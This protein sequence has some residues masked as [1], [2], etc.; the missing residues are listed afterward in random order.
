MKGKD[1]TL[2]Y[3]SKNYKEQR[4][5]GSKAKMDVER[6]MEMDG[7]RNVGLKQTHYHNP[8]AGYFMTLFSV[9]KSPWCMRAGNV[10][11]LQYPFKKYYSLLC[12]FA[13][14]RGCKVIT[15]IHDLGSFR[16]KK[17]SVVKEMKRLHRSD[18]IIAH[19]E[20]MTTWLKEHAYKNPIG[21]FEIWDYLSDSRPLP[22]KRDTACYEIIYAGEL[23][24]RKNRFLYRVGQSVRNYH[25]TLYG[26]RFASEAVE[27]PDCLTYRGYIPSD[28]LIAEVE[29]DFGLV[30]DGDSVG[31]CSG[32]WGEYLR[33]N[34]PH[35]TSLYIR[36]H[37]PLIVWEKSAMAVFVK[38]HRVGIC[39]NSLDE[40]D[41]IL[42]NMSESTYQDM[43]Q[44]V[45]E[46]SDKLASGYAFRKAIAS[47]LS[48]LYGV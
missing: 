10:L 5:A 17:L 30:W 34:N 20:A 40:L 22:R 46:L 19:N 38:K 6:I 31:G 29:G 7:F 32:A 36:C 21:R 26:K 44:R 13:H 37:L 8:V 41:D 3:I 9:L 43:K 23:D 48:C 12:F 25:L 4:S 11:V 47:A 28:R 15:L 35:K 1:V 16:R 24:E 39:V 18:Y 14:L 45:V 33:Y 27:Y 2:Y 42:A